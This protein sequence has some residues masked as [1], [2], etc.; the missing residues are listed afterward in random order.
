MT[1]DHDLESSFSIRNIISR[2]S[3]STSVGTVS[4]TNSLTASFAGQFSLEELAT[5]KSHNRSNKQTIKSELTGEEVIIPWCGS[6]KR[7]FDVSA[8]RKK[9]RTWAWW[10]I[11]GYGLRIGNRVYCTVKR[12]QGECFQDY[13]SN[14]MESTSLIN[15]LISDHPG[16]TQ[17]RRKL[18]IILPPILYQ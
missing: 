10:N 12:K 5:I 2:A 18:S 11:F 4:T 3:S 7:L 17:S 8:D 13:A 6:D 9:R 1:N 14:K 15:H 16:L